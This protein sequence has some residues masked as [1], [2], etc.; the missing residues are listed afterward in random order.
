MDIFSFSSPFKAY[1]SDGSPSKSPFN[2]CTG[3]WRPRVYRTH[4]NPH[5]FGT[6]VQRFSKVASSL[7]LI[8]QA[9]DLGEFNLCRAES[10][11]PMRVKT[12]QK[13]SD[14]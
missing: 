13:D 4:F 1:K 9:N 12:G 6:S 8:G 3:A 2:D 10:P 14:A 11:M 5:S 7:I